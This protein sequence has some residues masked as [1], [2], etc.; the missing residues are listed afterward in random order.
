MFLFFLLIG[1]GDD[2]V[3]RPD[4]GPRDA[5]ASDAGAIDS[6]AGCPG[7][8]SCPACSNG[9]DDDGD[10]LIDYPLD[11]GCSRRE[12]TDE[13]E[14]PPA[15]PC[16]ND[17]DDDDDGL[18]DYPDDPGCADEEDTD[19]ADPPPPACANELDDDGDGDADYPADPGCADAR[20]GDET[21]GCP[22][23]S[24][25]ACANG[26]DDDGDGE[27]DYPS[28][29]E[30]ESAADDDERCALI[31][32]FDH[33]WP[34]PWV[35][36]SGFP[37]FMT[38]RRAVA[39]HDGPFGLLNSY[40]TIVVPSVTTGRPGE[41]VSMWVR[42]IGD[43][44]TIHQLHFANGPAGSQACFLSIYDLLSF[45]ATSRTADPVLLE[46]TD[47][48]IELLTWYR[49][50]VAFMAG[51]VVECRVYAEGES[52]PL[53]SISHTFTGSL[54][55]PVGLRGAPSAAFDTVEVCR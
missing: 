54:E 1:C 34:G 42:T 32:S 38:A 45:Y 47:V 13:G 50:E 27:R 6:A 11:P 37:T 18:T 8:P 20:D 48:V 26:D 2:A 7:D 23:A 36:E 55:G 46:S 16:A 28:D 12:D 17:L 30:C 3:S 19:E 53:A 4:A 41:T 31:G 52:T 33:E 24:C 51:G 5:S 40:T 10:T 49:L 14:P 35:D 9:D 21:D 43:S 22:G 15:G 44:N 39:A 29:A 25:P